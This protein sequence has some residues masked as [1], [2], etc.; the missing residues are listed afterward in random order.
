VRAVK[1]C[2]K[3]LIGVGIVLVGVQFFRPARNLSDG[4]F[5]NDLLAHHPA[6]EQVQALL[7]RHCYDC[8]SNNTT[9]PWYANVQPVGWWMD[10]HVRDGKKHL[11]FSE[12]STY[13]PKRAAHKMEETYEM[14]EKREMPLPSY[15]ITHREAKLSDAEIRLLAGWARDLEK[16][17]LESVED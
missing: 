1:L 8:H 10:W 5:A 13:P 11:N 9:Y 3:I 17:I 7:K 16:K 15:T 12:F 6:P 14:V 4:P 2:G